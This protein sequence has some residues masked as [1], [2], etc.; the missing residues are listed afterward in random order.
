MKNALVTQIHL[1]VGA[2]ID[3]NIQI[4]V[5]T[6]IMKTALATLAGINACPPAETGLDEITNP[7]RTPLATKQ[8]S[9]EAL[10]NDTGGFLINSL[11][12]SPS[13]TA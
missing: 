7:R 3:K 12:V 4:I 8:S 6:K 5:T 9:K 10:K 13:A 2:T 1:I 11:A